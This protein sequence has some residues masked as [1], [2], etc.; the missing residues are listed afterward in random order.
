MKEEIADLVQDDVLFETGRWL[1]AIADA[2]AIPRT[3]LEIGRLRERAFRLVG[4]GTGRE[5]D[6]DRFDAFYRHLLVWDWR[7]SRLA[8]AYRLADTE[9]FRRGALPDAL[10]TSSLFAYGRPF[11]AR[12]GPAL[13]LGRAFVRPEYQRCSRALALL[14]QGI[15]VLLGR[16]DGPRR[17]FG[18]VSVSAR[19]TPRSRALIAA[20]LLAHHRH[21]LTRGLIR[22]RVPFAPAG[23][24]ESDVRGLAD[25]A[26]L[27]A[28]VAAL[29]PDGAG[30]PVLMRR[31]LQLGG[32]FAA[33]HVDEDFGGSLD[34]FMIL[35]PARSTSLASGSLRAALPLARGRGRLPMHGTA[36]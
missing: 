32:E 8:G 28:A 5:L 33:F 14:W 36:A 30:L 21:E 3:L 22:P 9:A 26:A 19:Y 20:A 13:E 6:L 17:L 10:Y 34:G 27:D 23:I 1:V 25:V 7:E 35:D 2:A 18:A 11:L 12:L 16:V 24:T 31:Y 15:A 29:E 4:E